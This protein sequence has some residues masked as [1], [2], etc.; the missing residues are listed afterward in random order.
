MCILQ[1]AFA[2]ANLIVQLVLLCSA[3]SL[4]HAQVQ[5]PLPQASCTFRF[6]KLAVNIPNLGSSTIAPSGI[7][8]FGTIVGTATPN[9]VPLTTVAFVRWANGGYS[10]PMGT[11]RGSSTTLTARNNR[12]VNIGSKNGV[13][14]TLSGTTLKVINF[15]SLGPKVQRVNGVSSINLWESIVG[16]DNTS[17]AVIG[18]KRWSNGSFVTFQFPSATSTFP[19][20]VNDFG[21]VVGGYFVGHAGHVGLPENGFIYQGGQWATLNEPNTFFTDLV[22]I[23]NA[24]VIVGNAMESDDGFLYEHGTFMQ[25]LDPHGAHTIITGISPQLGLIVGT[26]QNGGFIAT[27]K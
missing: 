6:F 1:K 13:P 4:S 8:D 12:G 21:T 20:G 26:S 18:F 15:S 5:T 10:F 9:N 25:I 23:S 24:G 27:C 14:I 17:T 16:S 7:N 19:T 22:G 3:V 2:P 11:V